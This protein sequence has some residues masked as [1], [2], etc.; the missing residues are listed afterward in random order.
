MHRPALR[1]AAAL[2]V[3]AVAALAV[4]TG[5]GADSHD[6]DPA[7]QPPDPG[8][9]PADVRWQTWQGVA[10]PIGGEDG[11][12]TI[13]ATASGFTQTPQGAALAAIQHSIRMALSPDDAWTTVAARSLVTGPGKDA[14]VQARVLVSIKGTD[15][16]VAPR[17]AGYEITNW[18]PDT[19]DVTVYTTYPDDS[20]L[21]SDTTVKWT[22]GDWRLLLPDPAT[23]KVTVRDVATV[24]AG[25]VRLEAQQ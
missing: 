13:D 15:P 17:I 19:T 24:P 14:W 9:A 18:T 3:A 4:L 12:T 6:P 1:R 7:P 11:P 22:A 10:L 21:A 5:C 8:R 20:V 2:A 25:A 16:S 23:Q